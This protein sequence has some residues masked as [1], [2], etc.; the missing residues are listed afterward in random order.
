M[1]R[2]F[3]QGCPAPPCRPSFVF[4]GFSVN[5]ITI[6][7]FVCIESFSVRSGPSPETA[8]L[9]SCAGGGWL[10]PI[11]NP[12]EGKEKVSDRQVCLPACPSRGPNALLATLTWSLH[13]KVFDKQH[14][15]P[16]NNDKKLEKFYIIAANIES[17]YPS[18]AILHARITRI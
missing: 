16:R 12:S 3:S 11:R 18:P 15:Q 10:G 13:R 8:P 7:Y 14:K 1:M 9:V 4:C 5:T 2:R 6:C 17:S